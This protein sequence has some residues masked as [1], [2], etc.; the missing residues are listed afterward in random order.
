MTQQTIHSENQRPAANQ[1]S[2]RGMFL[3]MTVTSVIFALLA[4]LIKSP[5]HWLGVL[6][7][8][9]C[10]FVIIAT[11]ELARTMSPPRPSESYSQP[12]SPK[13]PQPK[14]AVQTGYFSDAGAPFALPA[15]ANE[16]PLRQAITR[17]EFGKIDL[18]ATTPSD[19]QHRAGD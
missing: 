6:I 19:S 7:L 5:M 8:P 15:P 11:I 2:L 16:S 3:L 9:L 12:P 4:L 14:N 18:T 10:C 1:Y 13:T 17:G